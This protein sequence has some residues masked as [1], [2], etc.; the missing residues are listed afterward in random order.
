VKSFGRGWRATLV[1]PAALLGFL[2][3]LPSRCT[4]A[5]ADAIDGVWDLTDP[6]LTGE[7]EV[8]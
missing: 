5:Y 4:E 8:A 2:V 3:S 1:W 7:A 6:F